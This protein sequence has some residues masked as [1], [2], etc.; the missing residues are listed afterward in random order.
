MIIWIIGLVL[1]ILLIAL[2]LPIAFSMLTV[3]FLGLITLIGLDPALAMIGQIFFDNGMNYTLSI[4]FHGNQTFK[5]TIF[6]SLIKTF[7]R[8][9]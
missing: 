2:G 8:K 4:K 9:K 5:I 6:I 1:V 3:G 7:L